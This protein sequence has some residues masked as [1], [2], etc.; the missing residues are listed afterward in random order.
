MAEVFKVSPTAT[1]A[2]LAST[3]LFSVA[4]GFVAPAIEVA[5]LKAGVTA[6]AVRRAVGSAGLLAQ[7]G[8]LAGF[9]FAKGPVLG[10]L[11]NSGYN[12]FKCFTNDGGYQTNYIEVGREPLQKIGRLPGLN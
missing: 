1:G 11:C 12:F 7:A 2:Y 9:V 10:A 5:L 8:C 3:H 6:L 4:G